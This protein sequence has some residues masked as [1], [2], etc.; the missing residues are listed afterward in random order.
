MATMDKLTNAAEEAGEK[1]AGATRQAAETLGE[2]SEQFMEAEERFLKE[3]R[4][5]IREHPLASVGIALAAG[6]ILSQLTHTC[7]YRR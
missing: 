2:K 4:S 7:P 1:I 5:C 3:C 6:F